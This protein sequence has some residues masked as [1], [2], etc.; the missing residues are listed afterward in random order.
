MDLFLDGFVQSISKGSEPAVT[1][2]DAISIDKASSSLAHPTTKI[3]LV[4]EHVSINGWKREASSSHDLSYLASFI[5][6]KLQREER[7]G[8]T[9]NCVLHI[10]PCLV[11]KFFIKLSTFP[12]HQ[13]FPNP[14]VPKKSN[15]GFKSDIEHS[16]R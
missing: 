2:F 9:E 7:D 14:S 8:P 3:I 16:Y 13:N 4:H 11:A 10:S 12:S 5:V 15:P 6:E 1:G